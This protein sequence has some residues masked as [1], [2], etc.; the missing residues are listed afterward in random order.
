MNNLFPIE[1]E[2]FA[3]MLV[4]S[5]PF[6]AFASLGRTCRA[7]RVVTNDEVLWQARL[8]CLVKENPDVSFPPLGSSTAREHFKLCYDACE[9]EIRVAPAV[10][11]ASFKATP[12][13]FTELRKLGDVDPDDLDGQYFKGSIQLPI[14]AQA[15]LELVQLYS[16]IPRKRLGTD[17][18]RKVA[19]T[20]GVSFALINTLRK[21]YEKSGSACQ[22][23][24]SFWKPSSPRRWWYACKQRR[25]RQRR[26]LHVKHCLLRH[27]SWSVKHRPPPRLDK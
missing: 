10:R 12:H 16:S 15:V 3:L 24:S 8:Q 4:A 25:P 17:V 6:E 20:I 7:W 2:D 5:L 22:Q 23:R 9:T 14:A 21:D 13:L 19:E 18:N 26:H 11:V 27:R 1:F